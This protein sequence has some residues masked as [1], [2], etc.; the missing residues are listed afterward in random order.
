MTV[1]RRS[2]WML[3]VLSLLCFG[4]AGGDAGDADLVYQR[5][6][7]PGAGQAHQLE[8]DLLSA[9]LRVL[10]SRDHERE[11]M[12]AQ[13]FVEAT[14]AAAVLN[15]PFFDVDGSPMGLLVV[16]GA[17]RQALRRADWGV[18]Y[19]DGAGAHIVH[20][21]DYGGGSGTKQ[22]FQVGPRLVVDSQPLALKPQ[23]ARRTA[24][25]TKSSGKVV[26]LVTA[27]SVGAADLAKYLTGLGCK[28]ALNL[29]GGPSSQLVVRSGGLQVDEPGGTPVP[30]ALGVFAKRPAEERRER[31][32]GCR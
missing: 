7:I 23:S 13:E 12:T 30:I 29:D 18:F 10:D 9:E 15:G 16:D 22:A 32:G 4:E 6:T 27:D 8:I 11:A 26:A 1:P 3:G 14:G 19:T 25:C 5:V 2:A 20:T 17:Q 21:S 28:N 31:G 24:V